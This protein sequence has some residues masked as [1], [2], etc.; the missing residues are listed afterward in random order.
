MVVG[1]ALRP[2]DEQHHE[3]DRERDQADESQQRRE[4]A[5]A[6]EQLPP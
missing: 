5:G 3:Q 6:T 2:E 1:A 4:T